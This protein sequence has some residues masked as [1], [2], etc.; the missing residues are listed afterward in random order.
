M[1]LKVEL[2]VGAGAE[3]ELGE[4]ERIVGA[5][6]E[7]EQHVRPLREVDKQVGAQVEIEEHVGALSETDEQAGAEVEIEEHVGAL[8]VARRWV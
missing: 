5:E 8:V 4:V 7:I 3:V 2:W 1:V 6:V